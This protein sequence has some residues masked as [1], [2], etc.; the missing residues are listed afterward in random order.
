VIDGCRGVNVR[1]GD[2]AKAIE[3]MA[4]AGVVVLTSGRI[5]RTGTADQKGGRP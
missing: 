2:V 1:E 3:E 4:N 5:P